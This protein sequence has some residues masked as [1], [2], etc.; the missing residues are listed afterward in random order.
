ML[1]LAGLLRVGTLVKR[2]PH[3]VAVGFSAAIAIIILASQLKD[4]GGLTL[5]GAEP[6]PILPKLAVIISALP[7]LSSSAVGI[8]IAT[9]SAI[10]LV[11]WWRPAWPGML[12]A[13]ILAS[14]AAA[15]FSLPVET[16]GTRYGELAMTVPTLRL[17]SLT[18]ARLSE[19]LP[20]ALSFTL[21]GGIESLLSARV[22]DN[23]S[24]RQHRPNIELVAQGIANIASAAFG[25]IAVTGTIARTA[26]N[27]RAGA[28]SPVAGMMHAMFLLGFLVI[29]APLVRYIPL[30]AL[31]GILLVVCRD[32][33]DSRE[34]FRLL[35]HLRS[36]AILLTTF[37]L[38]L[39]FDL[40]TGILAGC[41]LSW[42]TAVIARLKSLH[43]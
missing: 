11:R 12:L 25:G 2:V 4:L 41:L 40:T 1:A 8:G 20:T 23:M 6:G 32:M 31:A 22:A 24:G 19:L 42:L 27:V 17:P 34:F 30:A 10:L 37:L 26:T 16:I 43:P 14:L 9:A 35:S 13:A 21:L 39:I 36:A 7:S 5:A 18:W 3:A 33:A 38:T 28:R 29:A 15:T